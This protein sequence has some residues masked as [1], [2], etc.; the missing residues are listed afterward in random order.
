MLSLLKVVEKSLYF[1]LQLR[2]DNATDFIGW[3]IA[4]AA[5][6]PNITLISFWW[7]SAMDPQ[8][9]TSIFDFRKKCSVTNAKAPGVRIYDTVK[10]E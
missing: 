8:P 6:A 3:S 4:E 7:E 5:T 2:Q 1:W 10:P 9:N